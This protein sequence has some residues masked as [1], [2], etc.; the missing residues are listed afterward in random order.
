M[1]GIEASYVPLSEEELRRAR[2]A[3]LA[4]GSYF[5]S[6]IGE[7]E[8][9]IFM[10]SADHCDKLGE[11]GLWYKMNFFQYSVRVPL[12]MVGPG[13]VTGEA[14]NACS[15]VDLL[16]T[17]LEITGGSIDMLGEPIDGRV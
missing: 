4:N 2:R 9:T 17:F 10:V 3:Y 12:V 14:E 13:I 16:P 1:D 15:F 5:D 11:R 6:K 8:N 7:L